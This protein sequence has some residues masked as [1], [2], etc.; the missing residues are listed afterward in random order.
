MNKWE[1]TGKKL[2]HE[3]IHIYD[4]NLTVVYASLRYIRY[5]VNIYSRECTELL[6]LSDCDALTLIRMRDADYGESGCITMLSAVFA[7][8]SVS[9]ARSAHYSGI[10]V[11]APWEYSYCAIFSWIIATITTKGEKRARNKTT[12][13]TK[14]VTFMSF[15]AKILRHVF[16]IGT[17][18]FKNNCWIKNS[19]LIAVCLPM[20][21]RKT[22]HKDNL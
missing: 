7:S 11:T 20:L 21:N 14:I 2:S 1:K 22:H 6:F 12:T 4:N 8:S 10:E 5:F 16:P 13:I 15:S 17:Y 3:I 9:N 19:H 18:W